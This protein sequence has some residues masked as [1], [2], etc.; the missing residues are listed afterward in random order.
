MQT[1]TLLFAATVSPGAV[2]DA[3]QH[4]WCEVDAGEFRLITDRPRHEAEDLVWRLRTFRPVAEGYLPGVPNAG[5]PALAVIVFERAR[6]FQRAMDGTEMSGFLQPSFDENLMVVGPESKAYSEHQSL[7]HEYVHYL[8]RTRTDINIPTWFDEG[9]AS[10]LSTA[11]VTT[12]EVEV[13]ALPVSILDSA[14]RDSRLPLTAVLQAEDVWDWHRS[15]RA[16]FYAWSW[17]LT[18]RLMLGQISGRADWRPGL[19]AFLAAQH[20]SLPESIDSGTVSLERR[21]ERYLERRLPRISHEV[22]E[23]F[24]GAGSFRCL[25]E[26]EKVRQLSLAIFQHNPE[27]A[28]SQLRQRIEADRDDAGLWTVLSLAEESSGNREAALAAARRAVELAPDDIS[29]VVRLAGALA[30]GCILEV[31]EECRARWQE[32]VPLLR[33]SLRQDPTRQDAVFT[34]GLAYL[35]SGRAGDAL[36]YLRIAHQRQPWAPHVNFYLGESYRLIGDVRAREH[37]TRARQWSPTELWRKLAEA[38]L[39]LLQQEGQQ[40]VPP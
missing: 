10:M 36:N 33:Q 35:Y 38:G 21:L 14:I 3:F 31:S 30:M 6:D 32:G 7:L 40:P 11:R 19:A 22:N 13:G 16:G 23:T 27:L 24:D 34:L 20:P 12:A 37:L 17:A 29:A 26:T 5:N 18:H 15:R 8:L 28:T 1:A 4:T 25:D 2:G 39:E 9:L